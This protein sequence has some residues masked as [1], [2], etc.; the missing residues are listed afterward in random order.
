MK[1]W[2]SAPQGRSIAQSSGTYTFRHGLPASVKG[3]HSGNSWDYSVTWH[4]VLCALTKVE[5]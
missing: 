5:G 2:P 1:R 3:I 4:A